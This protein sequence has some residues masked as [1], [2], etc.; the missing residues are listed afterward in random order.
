MPEIKV[1]QIDF[2]GL[3]TLVHFEF[4]NNNNVSICSSEN[5]YIQ[6]KSSFKKYNL[7]NNINLPFCPNV[8]IL[9]E[10]DQKHFFTLEFE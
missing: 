3:S 4:S 6:D 2:R 7:L 1:V 8:H 10:P 9:D 5:V